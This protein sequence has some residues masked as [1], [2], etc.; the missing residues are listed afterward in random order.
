MIDCDTA[1]KPTD[2]AV[3]DALTSDSSMDGCDPDWR[4]AVLSAASPEQLARVREAI[5]RS[6]SPYRLS[7]VESLYGS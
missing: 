3:A 7:A 6:P 5:A 2:K 1:H 4:S